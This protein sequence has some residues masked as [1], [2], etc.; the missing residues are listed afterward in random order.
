MRHCDKG[1][2]LIDAL[3]AVFLLTAVC[4]LCFSA[5]RSIAAYE[6][7]YRRYQERS[8]LRYEEIFRSLEGC[9]ACQLNEPD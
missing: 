9:E 5:S 6:E 2:I 4:Y 3:A 8:D 1:F 7:G